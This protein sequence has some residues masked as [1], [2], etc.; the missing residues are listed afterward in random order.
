MSNTE[1]KQRMKIWRI[2]EIYITH[3][4]LGSVKSDWFFDRESI[5][6]QFVIERV[7]KKNS[8]VLASKKL[9]REKEYYETR[10]TPWPKLYRLD[11][12]DGLTGWC[13]WSR[14]LMLVNDFVWVEMGAA[15]GSR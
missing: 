15:R 7:S 11:R 10:G 6:T 5:A 13:L 4:G 14:G 12:V 1:L 9:A 3:F 8:E 2:R